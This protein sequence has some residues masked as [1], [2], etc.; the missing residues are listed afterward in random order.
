MRLGILDHGHGLGSKLLFAIIRTASRQPVLDII[1]LVRYRADFYGK[2]ASKVTHEAMRGPSTWSVGD[3]EL[4]AA[5]IAQTN[6]SAFCK[7][8]HAA[9]AKAAYRNDARVDAALA[10]FDHAD[11]DETLRVTLRMLR[12]LA[13]EHS[14]SGEDMRALLAAGVTRAQIEDALHVAFSFNIITRLSEAFG[15]AIPSSDAMN[16][17][18][19]F[20]LARGYR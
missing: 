6:E 12:K 10:D 3:R 7:A 16:A 8:A 18:A 14:V 15:F 1:K 4:M 5:V 17:G 13:R 20:L 19:K 2:P 11:I 9:V